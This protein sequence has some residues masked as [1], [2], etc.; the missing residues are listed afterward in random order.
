MGHIQL[1]AFSRMPTN[2]FSFH[3]CFFLGE[4][5]AQNT[6]VR[7]SCLILCWRALVTL[8]QQRLSHHLNFL[9]SQYVLPLRRTILL[10]RFLSFSTTEPTSLSTSSSYELQNL[11]CNLYDSQFSNLYNGK[12]KLSLWDSNTGLLISTL[13]HVLWLAIYPHAQN[14]ISAVFF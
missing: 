14:V 11:G 1:M 7:T 2:F 6:L 12:N 4:T 10:G 5:A 3:C 13:K 8:P 9:W